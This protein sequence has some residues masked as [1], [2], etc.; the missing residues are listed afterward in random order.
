VADVPKRVG[1]RLV[2]GVKKFRPIVEDAKTRDVG[3]AD[4]VTVVTDML[5]ELF[6]YDK[7]KEITS[8]FPVKRTACD[9]ATKI[10]DK[11]QTLIEVKAIG[12]ELKDTHVRQAVDYAANQGVDWVVL[13]NGQ[14]WR[15]YFVKI[16]KPIEQELVVDIDF[17]AIDSKKDDDLGLLYLLCKEGWAK[18][19]IEEYQIHQEALSR[20]FVGAT[21]L[22]D[23]VLAVIRRELQRLSP[24]VRIDVED[25]RVVLEKDVI[26]RD[27]LEGDKAEVAR[28]RVARAANVALKETS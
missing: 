23:A 10:D 14:H 8:E 26:K 16:Q 19:V 12:H 25:V 28:K 15:A 21:L 20:F 13:T 22:G 6:G 9:I 2:A 24:E 27:V 5:A 17:L 11:L 3:E 7:F 18:S 1:E 4:T